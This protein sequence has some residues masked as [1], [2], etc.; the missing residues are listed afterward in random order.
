MNTTIQHAPEFKSMS[1]QIIL[2]VAAKVVVHVFS[3][4]THV[5]P[6]R[7]PMNI[8]QSTRLPLL[9]LA[10]EAEDG[11]GSVSLPVVEHMNSDL[12]P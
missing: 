7:V 3:T 11:G 1:K 9:G 5:P 8:L 6:I 2:T 12:I 4:Y 10:V